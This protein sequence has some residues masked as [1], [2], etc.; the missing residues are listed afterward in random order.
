MRNKTLSKL[1]LCGV[2]IFGALLF[3][4]CN[5]GTKEKKTVVV[6]STN[7]KKTKGV[8]DTTAESR[9]LKPGG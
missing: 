8:I 4:A 3:S 9:P 6:D 5:D 2:V 7:I 1:G